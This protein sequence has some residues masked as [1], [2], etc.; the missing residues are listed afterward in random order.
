MLLARALLLATTAYFGPGPWPD[1]P[2]PEISVRYERGDRDHDMTVTA[3]GA[4]A[5]GERPWAWN[6]FVIRGGWPVTENFGLYVDLGAADLEGG[7]INAGGTYSFDGDHGFFYGGGFDYALPLGTLGAD[8]VVS[9]SG[10]LRGWSSGVAG[11]E[12]QTVSGEFGPRIAARFADRAI[13][14][15][16]IAYTDQ[17]IDLDGLSNLGRIGGDANAANKFGAFLGGTYDFDPNWRGLLEG[18][19]AGDKRVDVGLAYRFGPRLRASPSR[20]RPTYAPRPQR[21]EEPPPREYAPPREESRYE[22]SERAA[23]PA[24]SERVPKPPPPPSGRTARPAMQPTTQPYTPTPDAEV[25]VYQTRTVPAEVARPS[26]A[27]IERGNRAV[28]LGRYQE[29]VVHYRQAVAVDPSNGRARYNLATAYY[30]SADFSSARATFE[31]A[32][33]LLPSDPEVFLYLGFSEYRL[34]NLEGARRAWRRVLELDP[35]NSVASNNLRV[36]GG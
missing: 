3:G 28:A 15:G 20:S 2:T 21:E 27:A 7:R 33:Q 31:A 6:Q 14:Y 16:G 25:P 10:N 5:S 4:S 34:G 12:L 24:R 30:L 1:D 19:V 36:I 13:I 26:E 18:A 35:T 8:V 22:E 29:A 23:P 32:T 11:G 9:I 17:R